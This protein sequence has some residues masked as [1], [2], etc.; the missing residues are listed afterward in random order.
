MCVVIVNDRYAATYRFLDVPRADSQAFVGHLGPMHGFTRVLIVSGDREA[1]VKRLAQEVSIDRIHAEQSPEQKIAIVHQETERTKT[2]F[3]GTERGRWA[4][5]REDC[6]IF[7]SIATLM[8]TDSVGMSD[9]RWTRQVAPG[10][11]IRAS[12]RCGN[13]GGEREIPN[14][15]PRPRC[16]RCCSDG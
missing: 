10:L 4:S 16:S 12:S 9:V 2:V 8:S 15:R 6:E 14:V 5:F 11:P 1:E 13:P 7:P 3:I